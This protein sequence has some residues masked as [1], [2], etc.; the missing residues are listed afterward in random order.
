[1]SKV[2]FSFKIIITLDCLEAGAPAR[3]PNPANPMEYCSTVPVA[4]QVRAAGSVTTPSVMVPVGVL[5]RHDH[6]PGAAGGGAGAE[7]NK[8]VMFSDGIRPGGDLTEL[9]GRPEGHRWEER[10]N[11]YILN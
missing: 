8:S 9:D 1:M 7:G 6:V 3:Q 11:K 5:K 2:F 4:D 10:N